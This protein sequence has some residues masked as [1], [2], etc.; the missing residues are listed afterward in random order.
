[1]RKLLKV[2]QCGAQLLA[3][4]LK[5]SKQRHQL[6]QQYNQYETENE[7]QLR[8]FKAKQEMKIRELEEKNRVFDT[9]LNIAEQKVHDQ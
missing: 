9:L 5:S 1:M 8:E 7:K 3:F 4:K 2:Q 6:L